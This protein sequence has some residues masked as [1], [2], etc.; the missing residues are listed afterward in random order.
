MAI[1]LNLSEVPNL[2]P[3]VQY[4]S[5]SGQTVFPYPFPITQDSDLIAVVNGVTLN[6]DSGY[7]LSGQGNDTGGNLTFTLGQTAGAIV[8]LFRDITIERITQ[9]GQNSGFSSTAFNAEYN[10]IYLIL[11]QLEASIGQCLQVPNTNNPA[12]VTLLTPGA[13]A[14]KYL[15][16]D[17]NGNPTPA[18]L[19]SSGALTQ[20]LLAGLLFPQT[21][22]E[23]TAPASPQYTG[24]A[25]F[26]I[27]RYGALTAN[28]DNL[29]AFNEAVAAASVVGGAIYVPAGTWKCSQNVNITASNIRVYGDGPASIVSFTATT[30]RLS[31]FTPTGTSL[32][33]LS[34]FEIDHLQIVGAGFGNDTGSGVS[35]TYVNGIR[36]HDCV[37]HDWNDSCILTQFG[38]TNG[39]QIQNNICHDAGQ[40]ISVFRNSTNI[41][42]TGNHVYNAL[43]FN[44]I[45]VEGTG[46]NNYYTVVSGN[47]VH[48]MTGNGS[49][50]ITQ[51]INVEDT[52]YASVTSNV[53]YNTSSGSC[54]NLFGAPF[55]TVVG[56]VCFNA[57]HGA[58]PTNYAFGIRL[59]A[60]TGNS[61]V[62]GNT[63]NGNQDGSMRL[64][65]GG[66]TYNS[67]NVMIW[68]NSFV[69]G[70]IIQ[71][72]SVSLANPFENTVANK[73]AF[74][75]LIVGTSTAGATSG[76][77]TNAEYTLID[78]VCHFTMQISYTST[79]GT[80]NI[81]V[82]GLPF[83][84]SAQGTQAVTVRVNG[85][86]IT[87]GFSLVAVVN[88][89]ATTINIS[90][91][92]PATGALSAVSLP[93][94][95]V[96]LTI[97]GQ[98]FTS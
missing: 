30:G 60:N 35:A 80:G 78:N 43:L 54:I 21:I 69:E 34:N 63:T 47:I 76:G 90:Q 79:T 12:P 95:L 52:V 41:V 25:G 67:L 55:S 64:D 28:A 17:A 49:T 7:T 44:G 50:G 75:P 31:G 93:A 59:G 56:N 39:V 22:F 73:G 77:V 33:P 85:L 46:G 40:V 83:T 58:V 11:Q 23:S 53:V 57:S 20:A 16:F 94:S 38:T 2:T 91:W 42:I 72:G 89:S 1:P 82:N 6:T 15:S 51:G 27:R 14:N 97:S 65:D 98:Y 3:Y 13:Y 87:A 66:G 86:P 48:D 74:S 92:N 36:I 71:S 24:Q 62:T 68:G 61:T 9:I 29:F 96:G 5:G 45:N 81:Q 84:S 4:V 32:A 26:D 18:V 37:V 19:T 8:T 70:Q 10:N 88:Q